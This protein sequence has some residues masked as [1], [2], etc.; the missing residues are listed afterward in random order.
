MHV[1]LIDD[2]PFYNKLLSRPMKDGGHEF[3]YSKTGKD[4]LAKISAKKPDLII[5]DLQLPD[6][7]GHDILERIR[8][9]AEF[10]S[11]PVIVITARNELG[12]KLKA[13]DLGADD[14]LVKPFQPE[15]LVAR[16]RILARRGRA[17]Q[18]VSEMEKTGE[19]FATNVVVIMASSAGTKGLTASSLCKQDV[20]SIRPM[21]C[22]L[23]CKSM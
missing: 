2:E 14:Y 6:M 17:M 22:A 19:K 8:R 10:N 12:E 7:S 1:L 4:G 11:I 18:I 13:F 3:E 20:S 5:V 15:E 9:D 23:F 21:F 16:L